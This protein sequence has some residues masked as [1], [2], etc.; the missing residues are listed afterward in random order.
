MGIL[1]MEHT[2]FTALF[3]HYVVLLRL[4]LRRQEVLNKAQRKPRSC[5]VRPYLRRRLAHGH[6][7]NLMRELS[8]ET[9]DLYRNF[10]C[11]DEPLFYEIVE[12]VRPYIQKEVTSLRQPLE[13]GLRVAITLRFMATGDSYKSLGYGFRVAHN[14]IS[15]IVPETCRAIIAAYA[16]EVLN[17]PRTQEEWKEVAHLF[18]ER[19]NFPHTVGA[20]DA[21]HIRIK[22]PALAGSQYFNYKKFY[23]IVLMAL[24]D[25]EYKFLYLDVGSVGSE[26]D[27]GIFAQTR[28]NTLIQ[29][30]QANLPPAE[31]LSTDPDGRPVEYFMVGD[32]AFALK[33]W[34][35]KPYP[36]R[37]L[38]T[39][40]RIFNY[41]LSRARRVVEN[42]FGILANR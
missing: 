26:S 28:L 20:L 27:A 18:E 2:F 21:K 1:E 17:L 9:P 33:P 29:T 37:G 39:H 24:V 15:L 12:K 14:T 23:S 35:V 10:M 6:Y 13:V 7:A 32:D 16:D 30:M 19:W 36:S 34:M 5:W 22:N 3:K 42:A 41:R 11:L 4:Q 8:L 25:A 38:S 40:E 31:P